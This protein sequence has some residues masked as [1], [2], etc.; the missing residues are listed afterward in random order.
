MCTGIKLTISDVYHWLNIMVYVKYRFN[1]DLGIYVN[2]NIQLKNLPT[3]EKKKKLKTKNKKAN[4][5]WTWKGH[6]LT[7]PFNKDHKFKAKRHCIVE[8]LSN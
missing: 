8:L 1:T 2:M 6:P 7:L 3:L 4:S 5:H